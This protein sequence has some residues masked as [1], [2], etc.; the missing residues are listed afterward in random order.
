M[1]EVTFRLQT[2]T[3]LFLAGNDQREIEIPPE[4]RQD[5]KRPDLPEVKYTWEYAAELRPPAFRGLM[6]YWLR[7]VIGGLVGADSTDL[8]R[9]RD[10]EKAIFGTADTGSM[11]SIRIKNASHLPQKFTEHISK[12]V[13]NE[14]QMTG[15][16]YLFWSM[17]RSGSGERYKSYRWYY[18]PQTTFDLTLS[19]RNQNEGQMN[20]AVAAL[21]LLTNLGGI[22]S[23]SRRCA[24]SLL[25]MPYKPL[26]DTL[27]KLSFKIAKNIDELKTLLEDG[28]QAVRSLYPEIDFQSVNRQVTEL[29]SFD[30]LSSNICQIWIL[31]NDHIWDSPDAAMEA[32]GSSLQTYRRNFNEKKARLLLNDQ[33]PE[34]ARGRFHKLKALEIFGLPLG[35]NQARRASP[36]LL[37][38]TPLQRG[39]VCVA[40]LFRSRME[41]IPAQYYTIIEDWINTFSVK[42]KVQI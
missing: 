12:K 16:G 25:A 39:Y 3:P 41:D 1:P 8:E 22:G 35:K 9:V 33:L 37:R 17:T 2:I 7:A 10:I 40:V 24:G 42:V 29:P 23:R 21:W 36:L 18:P 28:I 26:A 20:R 6:R 30:I 4:Y 31:C 13:N 34:D 27:S 14:Y 32:V 15:K 19:A 11:V 5:R 38:I